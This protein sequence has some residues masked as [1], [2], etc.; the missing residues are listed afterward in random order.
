MVRSN[1]VRIDPK[2]IFIFSLNNFSIT[3]FDSKVRNLLQIMLFFWSYFRL[4]TTIFCLV[5]KNETKGFPFQSGLGHLVNRNNF[6]NPQNFHFKNKIFA[7]VKIRF[8]G[9]Q[10]NLKFNI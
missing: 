9:N 10:K 7:V 3:K 2:A 1:C 6:S 5:M 8:S 4:Y